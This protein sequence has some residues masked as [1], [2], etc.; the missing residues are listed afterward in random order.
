MNA[1]H[2]HPL[3]DILSAPVVD[4]KPW[5]SFASCRDHPGMT[6][7]PQTKAEEAAAQ[8]ICSAC[9]VREQCLEHALTMNE[10]YGVWGGLTEKERR[11]LARL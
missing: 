9:P 10:R 8:A 2:P 5:A 7:F 1:M 4:E 3:L 6:F 11:R